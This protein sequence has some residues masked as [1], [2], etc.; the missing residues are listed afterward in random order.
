[1]A[2]M[3]DGLVASSA[4]TSSSLLSWHPARNCD[5]CRMRFMFTGSPLWLVHSRPLSHFATNA[6]APSS[7]FTNLLYKQRLRGTS[8]WLCVCVFVV[9]A[10]L[11]RPGM[12]GGLGTGTRALLVSQSSLCHQQMFCLPKCFVSL[13][14][15]RGSVETLGQRC[16]SAG[17]LGA[18]SLVLA[19]PESGS[20]VLG[21]L[22]Q[23]CSCALAWLVNPV[24]HSLSHQSQVTQHTST[25]TPPAR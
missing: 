24:N 10:C 4:L 11:C 21:C 2:P 18:G 23:L 7:L 8:D 12:Q 3:S 1:M 22:V 16:K 15:E 25:N 14:G 5:F 9:S 19:V 6:T 20:W 13:A 17:V